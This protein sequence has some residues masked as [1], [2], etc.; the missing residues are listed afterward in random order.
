MPD[1]LVLRALGLGDTFA[2]V[3]ALRALRAALPAY[4]IALAAPPAYG[5]LLVEAGVVDDVIA[6]A[7][8]NNPIQAA[9]APDVGVNLHGRGPQSHTLLL[10]AGVR[11]LVAFEH[12]A[13]GNAGPAWRA[14]EHERE[15]WCHLVGESFGVP[16]NPD[17]VRIDAPAAIDSPWRGC[18]LVHPGAASGARRWPPQR[19]A[20][21]VA[22]V[23]RDHDVLITGSADEV[24]LAGC[25][26]QRAGLPQ[27][28]V[29]A[30]RTSV[31]QLAALVA[32]AGLVLSGDTGIAHM[33]SGY[34]VPSVLL[35]GPTP[36]KLWG[37]PSTGPHTVLWKGSGTTDPHAAAPAR[38]LLEIGVDE[39]LA[40]VRDRF[41]AAA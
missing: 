23:A 15:R 22:A 7:G 28:R 32:A 17:A 18:V 35:F 21:V 30:G 1:A 9:T 24:P 12:A 16:T 31:R 36:P 25:V 33:A 10:R 26:G 4:R 6:C 20:D 5:Q 13:I 27:E 40:A 41:T 3:P 14:E 39:V 8:L 29:L 19:W 2:A 38:A 37:P 34:G 11:E